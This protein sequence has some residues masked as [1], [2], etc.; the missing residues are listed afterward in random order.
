M[1]AGAAVCLMLI[2]VLLSCI[3][4]IRKRSSSK[5]R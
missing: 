2:S 1:A 5:P 3:A 4:C